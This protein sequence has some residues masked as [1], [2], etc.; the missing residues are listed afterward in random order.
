MASACH[1]HQYAMYN[2]DPEGNTQIS[3]KIYKYIKGVKK[4]VCWEEKKGPNFNEHI[5]NRG[6][7]ITRKDIIYIYILLLLDK[8]S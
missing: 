6:H 7:N 8:D 4:Y 5:M 2:W 1:T 3:Y